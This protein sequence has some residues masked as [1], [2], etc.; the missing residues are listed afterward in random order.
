MLVLVLLGGMLP[1]LELSSGRLPLV[2]L[3]GGMC[4]VYHL[5]VVKIMCLEGLR[6]PM[7]TISMLG[8]I[9][10]FVPVERGMLHLRPIWYTVYLPQL[11]LL[12]RPTN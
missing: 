6:L 12:L 3:V 11:A 1:L 10:R 2:V 7:M 4:V 5:C 8:Y 9:G